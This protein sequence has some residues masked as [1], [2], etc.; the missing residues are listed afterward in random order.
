[1]TLTTGRAGV[2]LVVYVAVVLG[3]AIALFRRRDVT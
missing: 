1:M 2:T 3:V